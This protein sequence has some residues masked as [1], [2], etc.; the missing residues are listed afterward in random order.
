[1]ATELGHAREIHSRPPAGTLP[2]HSRRGYACGGK[3]W[4]D[5]AIAVPAGIFLLPVLIGTAL[6]VRIGLGPPILFRQE[7][8]GRDERIFRLFKFR[9]M[10]DARDTE[11]KLLPDADRLTGL[12]RFLRRS[13]FDELP[14]LLNVLRGELSLVGP[15]PLLVRYL[16]RYTTRQRLRHAVPPGMTGWAQVHGRNDLPWQVRL[17]HDVWYAENCSLRLDLAILS[18]TLFGML[19]RDP[20]I[21]TT[22]DDAGEFW[23]TVAPPAGAPRDLPCEESELTGPATSRQAPAPRPARAGAAA[24]DG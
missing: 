11:G 10:T 20:S 8:V 17:E 23:G 13:S 12:G 7:R 15:R 4:L 3:R 9:T 18:R 1:M 19:S 2:P 24:D 14:Q 5:L 21:A 16:P 22:G 6:A